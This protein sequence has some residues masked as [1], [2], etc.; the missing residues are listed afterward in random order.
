M[1]DYLAVVAFCVGQQCGFYADNHTP[2]L[3]KQKCEQ[4]LVEMQEALKQN[5]GVPLFAGCIPIKFVKV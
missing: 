4:R 1:I 3:N 5:G 2:F